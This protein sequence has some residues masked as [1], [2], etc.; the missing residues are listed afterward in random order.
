MP[1]RNEMKLANVNISNIM[2]RPYVHTKTRISTNCGTRRNATGS[3]L[4]LLKQKKSTK[5]TKAV[6]TCA[7][8]AAL[9]KNCRQF[10]S[11]A[12]KNCTCNHGLT[13][14]AHKLWD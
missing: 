13:R 8:L 4:R 9:C 6:V 7:I 3:K 14:K 1:G 11:N 10:K 2:S 5:S 12:C